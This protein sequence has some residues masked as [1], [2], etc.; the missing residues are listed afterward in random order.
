MNILIIDDDQMKYKY[1]TNGL[2]KAD[3]TNVV[4]WQKDYE[5][6]TEY[7]SRNA[8]YIDL[9]LLDWCFPSDAMSR[10]QYAMGK[11]VLTYMNM[12]GLTND[13]IICSSDMVSINKHEF[14]F[15]KGAICY[16]PDPSIFNQINEFLKSQ[17]EDIEQ[18]D[19]HIRSLRPKRPNECTGYKRRMSSQPWWQK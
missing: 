19:T 6:A 16:W 3:P 11:S 1:L 12:M 8:E 5:Q 4:R 7:I 9:I 18:K 10:P 13:V 2:L 15:V 17:E 14:P